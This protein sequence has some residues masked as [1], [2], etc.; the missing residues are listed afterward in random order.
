MK[1]ALVVIDMLHDFLAPDGKL[2]LG[3]AGTSV[4]SP[5]AELVK[6]ARGEGM[7]VVFIADRHRP[8]DREFEMF[9]PH[10]VDGTPGAEI[11]ADL[12][13]RSGEPVISKRRYSAFFGTDL[14][15]TLRE[16]E[17]GHLVLVGVCTNI[18]V[19][20]T[21][22]DARNLGYEVTVPS[23]AVASFDQDAHGWALHQMSEV[24]GVNVES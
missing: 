2:T 5:V 16:K 24:L 1:K 10:C 23:R 21:A 20:Y 19:L 8:D 3:D 15:L 22:A 12:S 14:D 13:P 18:C 6:K 17:I 11:V 7:P 9:P 4:I